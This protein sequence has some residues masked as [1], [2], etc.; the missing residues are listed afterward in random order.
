[1]WS[2]G[3]N[4]LRRKPLNFSEVTTIWCI[5]LNS[6]HLLVSFCFF[7]SEEFFVMFRLL[8]IPTLSGIIIIWQIHF[9]SQK[10]NQSFLFSATICC[11]FIEPIHQHRFSSYCILVSAHIFSFTSIETII[12]YLC[13]IWMYMYY[14]GITMFNI[15]FLIF[16]IGKQK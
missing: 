2:S 12:I 10:F 5:C 13:M 11:C 8:T 6:V 14:G 9:R 15:Q 16:F 4:N 3:I 7:F 1:M